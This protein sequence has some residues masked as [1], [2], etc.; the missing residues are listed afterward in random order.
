MPSAGAVSCVGTTK[1]RSDNAACHLSPRAP[2]TAP[3]HFASPDSAVVPVWTRCRSPASYDSFGVVPHGSASVLPPTQT[4]R[5]V[6]SQG[7]DAVT[8]TLGLWL[9]PE[10]AVTQH[11]RLQVLPFSGLTCKALPSQLDTRIS[12]SSCMFFAAR[13]AKGISLQPAS[14]GVCPNFRSA[15]LSSAA[16]EHLQCLKSLSM[17][18]VAEKAPLTRHHCW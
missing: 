4:P 13:P 16:A 8:G 17:L 11:H 10:R 9:Q 6:Y 18:F 5:F 2:A 3:S 1:P 7:E 14:L 15:P 12:V